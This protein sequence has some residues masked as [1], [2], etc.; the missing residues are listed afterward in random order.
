MEVEVGGAVVFCVPVERFAHLPDG[1]VA[2]PHAQPAGGSESTV[3]PTVDPLNPA[4]AHQTDAH[5]ANDE[6]AN[7]MSGTMSISQADSQADAVPTQQPDGDE[8]TK[9]IV[10]IVKGDDADAVIRALLSEGHRLTRINTTGGFLR[11]GNATLLIGVK[12]SE[13]DT[14]INLIESACPRRAEAAPL[15]KG[16][17]EYSANV[18]V[19]DTSHFVRV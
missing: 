18:F 16:L 13:V 9:L 1:A 10:A 8:R 14:I 2:G 5:S 6:E 7:V 12:T 3:D 15:E 4:D 19:L 11:R 17:P